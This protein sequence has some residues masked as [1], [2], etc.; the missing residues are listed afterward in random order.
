MSLFTRVLDPKS[1]AQ[2][3][4]TTQTPVL[5]HNRHHRS[6]SWLDC[7][8]AIGYGAVIASLPIKP[9]RIHIVQKD[10][11]DV[12]VILDDVYD[13]S[14]VGEWDKLAIRYGYTQY[15]SPEAE[16]EGLAAILQE[17]ADGGYL[18]L[19]DDDARPGGAS[20]PESCL[21]DDG[22]ST[23]EAIEHELAVRRAALRKMAKDPLGALRPGRPHALLQETF[24]PLY[25]HHRYQA[26]CTAKQIGGQR[27][28]FAVAPEASTVEVV[29][30]T[31]Q[32]AALQALLVALQPAELEVPSSISRFITPRPFGF[33]SGY[34]NDLRELFVGYTGR[35][36]DPIAPVEVAAG[37][38]LDAILHPHRAARLAMAGSGI[39]A[40]DDDE[41][42]LNLEEV[43][44]TIADSVFA[45]DENEGK[46]LKMI[47]RV[48]Q[49]S[50]FDNLLELASL[51]AQGRSSAEVAAVV[52]GFLEKMVGGALVPADVMLDAEDVSLR[53]ILEKNAANALQSSFIVPK[54]GEDFVAVPPGDPIGSLGSGDDLMD[55]S[56]G[57]L[58]HRRDELARVM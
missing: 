49:R 10:G 37:L 34:Q 36:F 48:V 43:L 41:S 39:I 23:I 51:T 27:Y 30:A 20:N 3:V 47:R 52:H 15:D 25:L 53:R 26:L 33:E 8:D 57:R 17:A 55:V 58:R 12:P 28:S 14:G 11:E 13:N 2:F 1:H 5:T 40:G 18:F 42:A 46:S 32:R 31:D 6:R 29:S 7:S 45:V 38:V 16:R 21:W 44:S 50:F 22:R 19:S 9:P 24:V 4:G 56:R 35:S 54:P